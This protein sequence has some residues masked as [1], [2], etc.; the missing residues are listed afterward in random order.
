MGALGRRVILSGS[1]G[2]VDHEVALGPSHEN[3]GA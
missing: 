2:S 1:D 3:D